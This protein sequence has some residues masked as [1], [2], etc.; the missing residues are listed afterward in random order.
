MNVFEYSKT[1]LSSL[2]VGIQATHFNIRVHGILSFSIFFIKTST[3]IMV[4][5]GQM[6]WISLLEYESL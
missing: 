6:N 2:S 4:E 5:H 1:E 3:Y